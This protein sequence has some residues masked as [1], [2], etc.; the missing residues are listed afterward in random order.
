MSYRSNPKF[1]C[2]RCN[3]N[4]G[5]ADF[6]KDMEV[7]FTCPEC[8][9]TGMLTT[10]INKHGESTRKT[11]AAKEDNRNVSTD[12]IRDTNTASE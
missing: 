8:K 11:G 1:Y 4:G 12:I 5:W 6:H 7:F 2:D 9:G 10:K 3:G